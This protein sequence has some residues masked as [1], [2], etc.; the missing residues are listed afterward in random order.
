MRPG[1]WRRNRF[2][3]GWLN[4]R[5]NIRHNGRRNSLFDLNLGTWDQAQL[6]VS[7]DALTGVETFFDDG[8]P[9]TRAGDYNLS[10][11]YG[12]V[13]LNHKDKLALLSILNC[14]RGHHN[15]VWLRAQR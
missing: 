11:I 2:Q 7:Y 4:G 5:V 9:T 1:P 8:L 14:L 12:H 3:C 10:R 6:P 13:G 15:G